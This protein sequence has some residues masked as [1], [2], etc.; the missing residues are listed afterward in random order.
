MGYIPCVLKPNPD[1]LLYSWIHRLAEA[2]GLSMKTFSDAYLGTYNATTGKPSIDVRTEFVSLYEH[3]Y[4]K[5]TMKDLYM[6]LSTYAFEA[7]FMS[8]GQQTR[9]INNIFRDK[10]NLN[11]F[12]NNLFSDI[13]IC[14]KCVITDID[15]FG[16]PYLHRSHQLSGVMTCYKHNCALITYIGTKGHACDYNINDYKALQPLKIHYNYTQYAQSL[17]ESKAKGNIHNLKIILYNRLKEFNYSASEGYSSFIKDFNRCKYHNLFNKDI[18]TFLKV[19]MINANYATAEELLPILMF[20][21]P[22][23]SELISKF[24]DNPPII[25]EYECPNCGKTYC[26]TIKA[27]KD[28]WDCPNCNKDDNLNKKLKRLINTIGNGNYTPI[29]DFKSLNSHLTLHHS[30]CGKDIKIKPRSFLFDGAK[31][32]CENMISVETAKEKVEKITGFKLIEFTSTTNPIKVYS[33]ECGHEFTCKYPKFINSPSCRICNPRIMTK[34]LFSNRVKELVGNEYIIVEHFSTQKEKV[35]LHHTLCDTRQEYRSSAFLD[36]QRCKKCTSLVHKKEF[37]ILLEQYSNGLYKI[38][39]YGKN[40]CTIINTETGEEIEITPAKAVQEMTRV[41]K[42][43]ILPISKPNAATVLPISAWDKGYQILCLYKEEFGHTKIAK[44]DTYQGY[45]LG[46][47]CQIQRKEKKKGILKEYRIKKLEEV[48]FI[49]DLLEN[50]WN[51]RYE[52]YKRYI[53]S[54]NGN[55]SISKRTIFEGETLGVWVE[56]QRKAYKSGKLSQKRFDKLTLLGM[57]F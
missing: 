7:L 43:I 24:K 34:E 50:E 31:C 4:I 55:I 11:A 44:G 33:E 15:E 21:F 35:V 57:T 1:E 45:N 36:G 14:P 48:G 12:I 37:E 2:N 20:I 5:G 29:T 23:V 27:Q 41:T 46:S 54:N 40:L 32:K 22:D 19:K 13:K 9:Y 47:W 25:V 30:L 56:I 38:F 8:E 51:R 26:S 49:W 28:G 53:T 17:F 42:S 18:E 6:S 39:S 10:S 16:S 52:Q 3:L